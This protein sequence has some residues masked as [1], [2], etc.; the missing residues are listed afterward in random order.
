MI[1]LII[2]I[3]SVTT[4]II[5][6]NVTITPSFEFTSMIVITIDRGVVSFTPLTLFDFFNTQH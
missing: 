3:L 2:V 6:I 4:I 5:I 1:T